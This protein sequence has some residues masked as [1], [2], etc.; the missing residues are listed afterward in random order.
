MSFHH[1]PVV[2]Q[3]VE[4][5]GDVHVGHVPAVQQEH[6][7]PQILARPHVEAH[8]PFQHEELVQVP[9]VQQ[10]HRHLNDCGEYQVDD[11][12]LVPSDELNPHVEVHEITHKNVVVEHVPKISLHLPSQQ[13]CDGSTSS[14]E[15]EVLSG[16]AASPL[17]L[18][19]LLSSGEPMP[20]PADSWERLALLQQ[21]L[22]R[23]LAAE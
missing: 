9:A 2:H 7:H 11:F 6:R 16:N 17:I 19:D 13:I 3:T 20:P 12:G 4:Q 5:I 23:Q 10:D 21:H 18:G 15:V 14:V 1:K 8:E 22:D